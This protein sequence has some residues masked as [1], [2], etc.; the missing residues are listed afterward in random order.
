MVFQTIE[1]RGER[2]VILPEREFLVLQSNASAAPAPHVPKAG[3]GVGHRPIG[4]AKDILPELP[5]SF[6]DALPT[7][8]LD[9]FEGRPESDAA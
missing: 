5:D 9:Q 6:F 8:V 7:E 2:Y 3:N 1:I 4:W